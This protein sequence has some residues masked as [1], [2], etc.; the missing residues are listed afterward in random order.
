LQGLDNRACGQK[1]VQLRAHNTFSK[2]GGLE[3]RRL[4]IDAD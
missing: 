1:V 4:S 3:K 2:K